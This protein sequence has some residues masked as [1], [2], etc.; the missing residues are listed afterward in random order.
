[1]PATARKLVAGALK[2][3]LGHDHLAGGE[4]LLVTSILAQRHQLGTG[5]H[6]RHHLVEL[7]LAVRMAEREHG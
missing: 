6:R 5:A 3:R 7:L 2:P 1:M 4:P